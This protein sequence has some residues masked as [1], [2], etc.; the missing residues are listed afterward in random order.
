[1]C[2]NPSVSEL[3]VALP[4]F[5]L[6][7]DG[8]IIIKRTPQ[9]HR[10]PT[11]IA[12]IFHKFANNFAQTSTDIVFLRELCVIQWILGDTSFLPEIEKQNA[13][14]DCKKYKELED[15]WGQE[16]L[17]KKRPDLQKSGNWTTVLG[18]E[19]GRELFLLQGKTYKKPANING[20]QPDGETEDNII[21]V[22][23]QTYFT[24]GTAGEKIM[25]VP[26]KYVDVPELYK[27]PLK[28]LCIAC[29]EKLG[30]EKYGVL[31]GPALSNSHGKQKNIAFYKS[32]GIEYIGATDIIRDI[33]WNIIV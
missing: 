3:R 32:N 14:K 6:K 24:S 13:T 21:E 20:F 19:I 12:A 25:G 22:K 27:K 16:I 30:R 10:P 2:D 11:Q 31:P 28:I 1:M 4:N 5:K 17:A 23:S 9:P 7:D 18:E 29:A 33:V 15:V 26:H 8:I